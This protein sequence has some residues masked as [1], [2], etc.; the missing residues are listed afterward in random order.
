MKITNHLSFNNFQ[1]CIFMLQRRVGLNTFGI[2]KHVNIPVAWTELAQLIECRGTIHD[3]KKIDE[4][5]NISI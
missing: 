1:I 3:G 4:D 2:G 5:L